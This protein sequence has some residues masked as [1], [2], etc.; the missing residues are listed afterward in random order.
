MFWVVAK[1]LED[2]DL[3][4]LK[5]SEMFCL[6]EKEKTYW[7]FEPTDENDF[8]GDHHYAIIVGKY[9]VLHYIRA[10]SGKFIL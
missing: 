1:N 7:K 2:R 4:V 10:M 5:E 8:R 9:F 6:D 3:H